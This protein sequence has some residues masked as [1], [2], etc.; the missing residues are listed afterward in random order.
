MR[1]HAQVF[2]SA[3]Y[4]VC[5]QLDNNVIN[6]DGRTNRLRQIGDDA[7]TNALAHIWHNDNEVCQKRGSAMERATGSKRMH[8]GGASTRAD[9]SAQGMHRV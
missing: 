5:F 2:H 7:L 8:M 4:L 9:R 1:F 3:T 6:R